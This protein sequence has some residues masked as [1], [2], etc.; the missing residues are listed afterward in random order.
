[1]PIDVPDESG[2]IIQPTA[3]KATLLSIFD[4]MLRMRRFEE[5][6]IGLAEQGHRFGH[7]H[8][9]IGQEA[10]GAAVLEALGDSDLILTTHRNH[11]HLVG[12]GSDPARMMAEILGKAT[13]L[14]GGRAGTLHLTDRNRG[15]LQTSAVVGGVLSLCIGAA[16]ALKQAADGR[17]AVAFFGDGALEEGVAVE[18][19]NIAALW[20]LPLLFV[21]ENNSVGA[22][23]AQGGGYPTSV[24]AARRFTDLPKCFGITSHLLP[25][26]S[27]I[28]QIHAVAEQAVA[29]CR[30]GRGPVFMETVTERWPGSQP[31]WPELA[32][33]ITDLAMAFGEKPIEGS[34]RDWTERHDPVLRAACG[35]VA[36]AGASQEEL[37][38]LDKVVRAVMREAMRFAIESPMP[39][40]AD[41]GVGAFAA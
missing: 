33:G 25:E 30:A 21:C 2:D 14:C 27:E 39:D 31:L 1:M 7:Y 15:F 32:T 37:F 10:T 17:I 38:A 18:A 35:L 24:S 9:Y 6:V 13:G 5:S 16:Y 29:Q 11:G 8:V 3:D 34:H 22:I 40:P 12:R 20:K 23:G 28:G 4:R 41:V 19:F 26:A 36:A